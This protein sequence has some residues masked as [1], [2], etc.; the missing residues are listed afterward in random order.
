MEELN[1]NGESIGISEDVNHII[2][3]GKEAVVNSYAE[4]IQDFGGP[5]YREIGLWFIAGEF[6]PSTNTA[7]LSPEMQE[8]VNPQQ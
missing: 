2:K 1:T 5:K 3:S 4:F 8:I 7:V 6:D